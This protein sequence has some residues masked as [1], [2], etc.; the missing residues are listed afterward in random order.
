MTAEQDFHVAEE[1]YDNFRKTVQDVGETA[2]AEWNTMLGEYAQAYPELANEFQAK[3]E[4]STSRRLG[5]KPTN[6]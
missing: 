5:A 6:L 2:Q 1:V 4:R 3:N